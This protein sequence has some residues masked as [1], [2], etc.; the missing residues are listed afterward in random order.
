LHAIGCQRVR[1][2]CAARA[3]T[4]AGFLTRGVRDKVVGCSILLAQAIIEKISA[5]QLSICEK[6]TRIFRALIGFRY[7]KLLNNN[8]ID[9]DNTDSTMSVVGNTDTF[10]VL[11]FR[12][13]LHGCPTDNRRTRQ[14]VVATRFWCWTEIGAACLIRAKRVVHAL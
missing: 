8:T 13:I 1:I 12:A 10:I 11:R 5:T 7:R 4:R 9:V 2:T 6:A 14:R 3:T